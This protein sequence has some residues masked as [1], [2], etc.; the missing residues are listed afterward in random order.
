M[1]TKIVKPILASILIGGA[2][3]V[4]LGCD[5]GDDGADVVVTQADNHGTV[6]VAKGGEV[7]VILRGNPSTGYEWVV[8]GSDETRM[9]LSGSGF[10]PDNNMPGSGGEYRFEFKA[11]ETGT[12]PLRLVYKRSW[13]TAVAESFDVTIVIE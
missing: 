5:H 2:M 6:S 9:T 13:E 1:N 12:V 4:T 11:I 10:V 7:V 3:H 8:A